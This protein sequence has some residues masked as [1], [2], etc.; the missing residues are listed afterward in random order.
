MSISSYEDTIFGSVIVTESQMWLS[1]NTVHY[2]LLEDDPRS[3]CGGQK[4][5]IEIK[6]SDIIYTLFLQ[7]ATVM[8]SL[9]PE[10]HHVSEFSFLFQKQMQF[11]KLLFG[12]P[13]QNNPIPHLMPLIFAFYLLL[14]TSKRSKITMEMQFSLKSLEISVI[15]STQQAFVSQIKATFSSRYL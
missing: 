8:D 14:R 10:G 12:T 6:Y 15:V 3:F 4:R 11:C 7:N 9:C 5:S 2:H 13:Y 1:N